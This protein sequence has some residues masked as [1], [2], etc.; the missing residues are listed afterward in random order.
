MTN[1]KREEEE[2]MCMRITIWI[3]RETFMT[4]SEADVSHNK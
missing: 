3:T 4:A 1:N 2:H